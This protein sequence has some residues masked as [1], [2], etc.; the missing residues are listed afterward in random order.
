MELTAATVGAST[1]LAAIP[2]DAT[3]PIANQ[4]IELSSYLLI[5]VG[6]IFLEKILLTLT[7]TITFSYLVPIACVL[8]GIYL[9]VKKDIFKNLAIK[10]LLFGIVVVLVVPISVQISNIIENT[11]EISINQTIE[12]SKNIENIEEDNANKEIKEDESLWNKFSSKVENGIFAIGENV[13]QWIE[14][15]EKMLSNFIDAIAVLLITS[16]VIPIVVLLFFIW[17]IK[18]I[19]GI[20]IPI[21]K[22]KKRDEIK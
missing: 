2:G 17:I 20:N 11:Y 1:A 15:G 10:L 19:F 5:V 3:T 16:C 13:S 22:L 14:K 12:D 4:I 7:G 8:F 18:I 9:F 6:A 21:S